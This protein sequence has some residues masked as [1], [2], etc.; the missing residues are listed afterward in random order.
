MLTQHQIAVH[1]HF[2]PP[3]QSRGAH[4]KALA[5]AVREAIVKTLY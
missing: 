1:V 3:L 5:F 4:R 2:L